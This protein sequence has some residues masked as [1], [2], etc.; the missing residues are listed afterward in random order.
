MDDRRNRTPRR[1][2]INTTLLQGM[3]TEE[4]FDLVNLIIRLVMNRLQIRRDNL[5]YIEIRLNETAGRSS[6]PN[7]QDWDDPR[8]VLCLSAQ[9]RSPRSSGTLALHMA[10]VQGP[11]RARDDQVDLEAAH[12]I[13]DSG[14][15]PW[16]AR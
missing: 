11:P 9:P 2:V 12:D 1:P 15:P 4:L 14:L 16:R 13:P 3:T 5:Q 6:P 7:D 8:N 10:T